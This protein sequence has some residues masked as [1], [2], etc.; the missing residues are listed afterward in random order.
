MD[1]KIL[2]I[3]IQKL[4]MSLNENMIDQDTAIALGNAYGLIQDSVGRLKELHDAISYKFGPSSKILYS[5]RDL[6][7]AM[8]LIDGVSASADVASTPES[9]N[10]Q[11]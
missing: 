6:R 10:T 9:S 2:L 11:R 1:K 4:K 5:L 8:A 7:K 3:E